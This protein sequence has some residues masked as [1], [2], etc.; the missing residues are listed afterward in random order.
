MF[1]GLS[2]WTISSTSRNETAILANTASTFLC[3]HYANLLHDSKT[4]TCF[5]LAL[6]AFTAEVHAGCVSTPCSWPCWY[7]PCSNLI[8]ISRQCFFW[9]G[10]GG[11]ENN[12]S[13]LRAFQA[14]RGGSH[15][16]GCFCS[17]D[18]IHDKGA[19]DGR[20]ALLP[21]LL[22][23]T[24]LIVL[25]CGACLGSRSRGFKPLLRRATFPT[26]RLSRVDAKLTRGVQWWP[27]R[28]LC[29]VRPWG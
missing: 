28:G 16:R 23:L 11:S 13:V 6:Y 15:R 26:D 29:N 25:H 22:S 9:V 19:P 14:R 20:L 4:P 8:N 12:L 17:P 2:R 24:R 18:L 3:L 27:G 7:A 10:G 5:S 1:S 21:V